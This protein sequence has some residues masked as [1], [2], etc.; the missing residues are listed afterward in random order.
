MSCKRKTVLV[1]GGGSFI[2]RHIVTRLM[3]ED[4]EV[5][6]L[7]RTAPQAPIPG[8][9]HVLGDFRDPAI[10]GKCLEGVHAIY[11]LANP[12]GSNWQEYA[13]GVVAPTIRI[14]ESAARAG[15]RQFFF[16]SSIDLYDSAYAWSRVTG[17]TGADPFIAR[18]NHYA[19]AKAACEQALMKLDGR[20]GFRVTIFRLG[21][22]IGRGASPAHRGVGHFTSALKVRFWGRGDHRLPF[23]LVED[24]AEAFVLALGNQAAAGRTLLVSA[25]PALSAREYMEA[26]AA[27][28]LPAVSY[29]AHP[30]VL[31]WAGEALKECV[32][33]LIRHP[34]RRVAS[35]HDWQCRAHRASYDSSQT[36]QILGWQP[37]KDRTTLI[38]RGVHPAVDEFINGLYVADSAPR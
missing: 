16:A 18:R 32:K 37:V 33:T 10:T 9:E 38:A 28:A 23:V 13:S 8:A 4:V 7:A 29:R 20:D 5:R 14:A 17:E 6:I 30:I 25:P 24:A 36:E 3:R 21:L 26:V 1:I 35:L 31:F 15:V 12:V 2:A 27:R 22:T 34:N 19:R 11:H